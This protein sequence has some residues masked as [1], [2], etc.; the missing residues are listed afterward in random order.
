MD[1]L[2]GS[3]TLFLIRCMLISC[4]VYPELEKESNIREVART[5]R[6]LLIALR[7]SH[8]SYLQKKDNHEKYL[9]QWKIPSDRKY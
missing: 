5:P 3:H 4:E 8:E 7:S 2:R 1:F 6:L 9:D